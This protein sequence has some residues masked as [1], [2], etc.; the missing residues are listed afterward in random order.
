MNG[1]KIGFIGCGNMAKT[2]IAGLIDSGTFEAGEVIAS[3]HDKAQ[4]AEAEN[5]YG[6]ATTLNNSELVL[7]S[8][9]IVLAVKPQ[10]ISEVINEICDTVS[11]NKLVISIVAG[12]SIEKIEDMFGRSIKL[13][14]TMPNTPALAGAGM[15]A[16][17]RNENV[18]D[19]E[20]EYALK[21]LA[22]FGKAEVIPEK[23]MDAVVAVSGSGPAYVAIFIE[24]MADAAVMEGMPRKQAYMFAEQTVYGTA[25]LLMEKGLHPAELKDMVCSP[26]GTTI[27]AVKALE[28]KGFRSAVISAM[29]ECADISRRL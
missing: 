17:C 2:I 26:A 12:Q 3:D 27:G 21:I 7:K 25:K 29:R 16:V 24:A 6:I 10:I 8:E 1:M 11:E 28:D 19:L 9:M 18:T 14:R 20:L 23:L 13:I 4:L 22:S 15:T 5:R